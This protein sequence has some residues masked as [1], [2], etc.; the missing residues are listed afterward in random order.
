MIEIEKVFKV[1]E[2]TQDI[3]LI[4]ENTYSKISV[5]GEISNLSIPL[6]GH[7]YF[8][9]KDEHA[10]IKCVLFK[11]HNKNLKFRLENGQNV[12]CKGKIS[13]Y[14]KGGSYQIYASIIEPKGLGAL[15]LAFEQLKERLEKQGLFD[16]KYKK[17]LPFLPQRIGIVTSKTGAAIKDMVNI[18]KRR[19][20]FVKIILRPVRVQG[21]GAADE[22]A[23]AIEE[24][25]EYKKVD[26]LIVGR[27]GGSLE[28]LWAFNEEI[29]AR[30]IF[31]SKLPVIS[32]VGHERDFTISD[33]VA[34]VRAATPSEAAELVAKKKNDLLIQLDNLL[35]N[36]QGALEDTIYQKIQTIDSFLQNTNILIRNLLDRATASLRRHREK[37]NILS[38]GQLLRRNRE[39]F[40]QLSKRMHVRLGYLFSVNE[41]DFKRYVEKLEVLSPLK[42]LSRGYSISFVMPEEKVLR[43]ISQIKVNGQITTKLSNGSFL[44]VVKEV[45]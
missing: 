7:T 1:S 44:S 11:G 45:D 36:A 42:V 38:P 40:I 21:E 13:V 18:L 4:L 9:L 15:Q 30:S 32:S 27:G 33:F 8:T 6:S 23:Q 26:V 28:D 39:N 5:E 3:K 29:V 34:D 2:I 12:I 20:P 17:E 14:E 41:Q 22:I 31:K 35:N 25:N 24:F 19:A 16:V 43:D 37:L 10:S